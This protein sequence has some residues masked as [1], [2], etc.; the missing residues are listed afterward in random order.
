MQNLS[1]SLL[2]SLLITHQALAMPSP[3]APQEAA[4]IIQLS[5]TPATPLGNADVLAMV[6]A[7]LA[8]DVIIRKIK[9]TFPSFFE[10]FKVWAY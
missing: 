2:L 8:P 3:A 10:V 1:I 6:K 7:N 9:V 5:Q 4:K